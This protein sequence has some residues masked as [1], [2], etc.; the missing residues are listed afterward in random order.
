[1]ARHFYEIYFLLKKDKAQ[2]LINFSHIPSKN[3]IG[4][5]ANI[6]IITVSTKVATRIGKFAL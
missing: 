4:I 3:I 2:R 1:L 5:A 6:E